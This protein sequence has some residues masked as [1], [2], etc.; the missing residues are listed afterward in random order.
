MM[1]PFDDTAGI[2]SEQN[3]REVFKRLFV[4][5]LTPKTSDAVIRAAFRICITVCWLSVAG[6]QPLRAA[7][8]AKDA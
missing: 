6:R 7:Q 3:S 2:A 8:N 1:S 4:A 5:A